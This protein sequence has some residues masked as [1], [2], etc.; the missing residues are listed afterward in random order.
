MGKLREKG[1]ELCGV[2]MVEAAVNQRTLKSQSL[3]KQSKCQTL[4]KKEKGKSEK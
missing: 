3:S 4:Y 2:G 1:R